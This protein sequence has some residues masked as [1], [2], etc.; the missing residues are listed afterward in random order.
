MF[1]DFNSHKVTEELAFSRSYPGLKSIYEVNEVQVWVINP[2]DPVLQVIGLPGATDFNFVRQTKSTRVAGEGD[3][4]VTFWAWV[5]CGRR[6]EKGGL[7]FSSATD[8]GEAMISRSSS[9]SSVS[10]S[11]SPLSQVVNNRSSGDQRRRVPLPME[12]MLE[13]PTAS[14]TEHPEMERPVGN[15]AA[16]C[17]SRPAKKTSIAEL[18]KRMEGRGTDWPRAKRAAARFLDPA[19]SCKEYYEDLTSAFPEL[20]LYYSSEDTTCGRTP[21]DEYQRTIGAL[22]AMF[23]LIRLR[24]GGRESFCFGLTKDWEPRSETSVEE[25]ISSLR[26]D[27]GNGSTSRARWRKQALRQEWQKKR[28]FYERTDWAKLEGLIIDAGLMRSPEGPHDQDRV[29]ALMV[30]LVIHDVFKVKSLQPKVEGGAFMGYRSGEVISDHDA[31]LSFVLSCHPEALPSFAGLSQKQRGAIKLAHCKLE[32]NMGWFVQAEAPPG[33]VLKTFKRVVSSGRV[34]SCDIAFYFVHWLADLAGAEPYPLEGCEK[35][36][37]KFP[38]HVFS[39]LLGP[40]FT[41]AALGETSVTETTM[42][43]RYLVE[44]WPHQELGE[45]PSGANSIAKMRLV[46]MAQL[47]TA[48]DKQALMKAYGSLLRE[49]RSVLG[50]ELAMTGCKGQAFECDT[51][52]G[53][54][55]FR[56][57]PAFLVYYGPA[58]MQKA[59]S[60]DPSGAMVILADILRKARVLWPLAARDADKTVIVRIDVIKTLPAQALAFPDHDMPYVLS[61]TNNKEASIRLV[62]MEAIQDLNWRQ[63]QILSFKSKEVTA[64]PRA[65]VTPSV[66]HSPRHRATVT[67]SA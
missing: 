34:P 10:S 16:R 45:R 41:M 55:Y 5:V 11:T 22:F 40:C 15:F 63:N 53:T 31:A 64:Y 2:Q 21:D 14:P 44:R 29:L 67:T 30:L 59:G 13:C 18:A 60:K 23:W 47:H 6:R 50:S 25:E 38:L 1:I 28:V 4:V 9:I 35:L 49:D 51:L 12:A 66:E 62:T 54:E 48:E 26:E 43:E 39:R 19:Y 65:T 46:C 3:V 56:K 24:L 8:P 37:M 58:L 36:T 42:V 20:L 57:G 32:Y 61:R 33:A 52:A 27:A 7:D 17:L